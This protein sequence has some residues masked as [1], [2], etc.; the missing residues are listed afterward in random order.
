[1]TSTL[2]YFVKKKIHYQFNPSKTSQFYFWNY[3]DSDR[4]NP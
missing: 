2:N 1:M 4:L 3:K